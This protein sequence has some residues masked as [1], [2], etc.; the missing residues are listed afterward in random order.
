MQ[1]EPAK[2]RVLVVD[3]EPLARRMLVA[4]LQ[5]EADVVVVGECG[6]GPAAVEAI[7]RGGA[8]VVFLD[9]QMPGLDG[10]GVVAEVGA[11]RMPLVVFATAYDHYA[12]AAFDAH[13]LDYL[14]KPYEPARLH[15]ALE[16]VRERVLERRGTDDTARLVGLLA[17][18]AGGAAPERFMVKVGSAYVPV[19]A[20]QIVWVEADDDHVVLHAEARQRYPLRETMAALEARL[21]RRTFLRIHRSYI[22]NLDRVRE[23]TPWSGTEYQLVMDDGSKL[24]TGR[25]FRAQVRERLGLR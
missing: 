18:V 4:L 7:V 16:R 12:V 6:N 10:F 19:R 25:S 20:E 11:E 13:A 14:L 21:D 5:A 3:D 8:D 23:V 2:L 22:V 9:V 24:L 1:T 15:R 17:G